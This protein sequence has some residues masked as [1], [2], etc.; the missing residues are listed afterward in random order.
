MQ[1]S[2]WRNYETQG[3]EEL[4]FLLHRFFTF[5]SLLDKNFER[6]YRD[7]SNRIA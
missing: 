2:L 5:A 1:S 7:C 4:I 6:I 3:G